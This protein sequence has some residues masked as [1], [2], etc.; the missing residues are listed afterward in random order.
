MS[1]EKKAK[2]TGNNSRQCSTESCPRMAIEKIANRK[3]NNVWLVPVLVGEST[4][5]SG[6][7]HSISKL[8]VLEPELRNLLGFFFVRD[9]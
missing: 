9:T 4:V 7:R 2:R 3:F 8:P 1:P 6:V 5:S